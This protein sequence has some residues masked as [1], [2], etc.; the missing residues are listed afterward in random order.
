MTEHRLVDDTMTVE[1]TTD[2][3]GIVARCICG[4]STGPRFTSAVASALFRDHRD[5]PAAP[6][7]PSLYDIARDVCHQQGMDWTDPR[8]GKTYAAPKKDAP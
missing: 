8:T 6:E 4:W 7:P 1:R 2:G 3:T 5:N